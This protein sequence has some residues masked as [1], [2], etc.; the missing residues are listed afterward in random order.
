MVRLFG[1]TPRFDS[2]LVEAH[3]PVHRV[4]LFYHAAYLDAF[5]RQA[6]LG[7]IPN[8]LVRHIADLLGESV[9]IPLPHPENPRTFFAHAERVRGAL[10][11]SKFDEKARKSFQDWLVDEAHRSEDQGWLR[12]RLEERLRPAK[13][14]FPAPS[15]LDRMCAFASERGTVGRRP[16]RTLRV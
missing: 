2:F 6:P 5:S 15:G 16:I 4:A 9:P 11:W 12:E 8:Y 13:V 7:P 1:P 10:G 14:V 3:G